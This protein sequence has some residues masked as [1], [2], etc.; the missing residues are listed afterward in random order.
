MTMLRIGLLARW[1]LAGLTILGGCATVEP[2]ER[3][4][5]AADRM[6]LDVDPDETAMIGARRRTREEGVVNGTGAAA[7]SSA[8]AGGGCGCH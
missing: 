4:T 5:L 3:G 8:S 2:W 7:S 6:Q 1:A